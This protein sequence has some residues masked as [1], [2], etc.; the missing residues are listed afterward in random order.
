MIKRT[1]ILQAALLCAVF[2]RSACAQ[3]LYISKVE[4]RYHTAASLIVS[5]S[6]SPEYCN[7]GNAPNFS[8]GADVS[9]LAN[10]GTGQPVDPTI[11]SA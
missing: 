4:V 6:T 1:L 11:W 5:R 7:D 8:N 3:Q 9:F 10:I 2:V